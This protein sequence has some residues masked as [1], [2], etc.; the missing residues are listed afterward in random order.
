MT[1][2]WRD[3]DR[4]LRSQADV[5]RELNISVRQLQRIEAEALGTYLLGIAAAMREAIGDLEDVRPPRRFPCRISER[6]PEHVEAAHAERLPGLP[7][8]STLSRSGVDQR[9]RHLPRRFSKGKP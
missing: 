6:L 7:T 4:G 8:P 3:Y 5:A 9:A 2:P 1:P